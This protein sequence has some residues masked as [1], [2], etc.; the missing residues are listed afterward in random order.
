MH[1]DGC[2][3]LARDLILPPTNPI[4]R[5]MRNYLFV[6]GIFLA[7]AL[8]MTGRSHA[9]FVISIHDGATFGPSNVIVNPNDIVTVDFLLTQTAGETRLD[10]AATGLVF[11][12]FS[13]T[14]SGSDIVPTVV[15]VNPSF[16]DLGTTGIAGQVVTL[17]V[18]DNST[19]FATAGVTTA[20]DVAMLD[21][22]GESVVIGSATFTV[23]TTAS[24]VHTV[25]IEPIQDG[26]GM[27]LFSIAD[28]SFPVNIDVDPQ[29]TT[30]TFTVAAVPEPS[31][32]AILMLGC[33]AIAA[34]RRRRS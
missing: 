17:D 31:S 23:G 11:A 28:P 3:G 7:V 22:T 34:R 18:F 12:N 19:P 24:G 21:P 26:A 16:V 20:N 29:P 14:V 4:S 27:D 33:A 9:G 30:F 8:S 6:A 25:T 2:C 32:C 1:S 5:T 15:N 10:N 13:A